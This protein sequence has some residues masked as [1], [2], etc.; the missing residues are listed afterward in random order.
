MMQPSDEPAGQARAVAG[1]AIER[2]PVTE[3]ELSG[4][5]DAHLADVVQ[6]I[7]D[8]SIRIAQIG[9]RRATDR[10]VWRF[11]R[12][13]ATRRLDAQ[14]KL[15]ARL[16]QLGIEAASGPVSA[17]VRADATADFIS[18]HESR[19][20]AFDRVYLDEQLRDLTEATALVGRIAGHVANRELREALEGLRAKLEVDVRL[21]RSV[22]EDY[23][24]NLR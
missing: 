17:L 18:L 23:L 11:A 1:G 22:R 4:L 12:D 8:D 9:E 14:N 24:R 20:R 13:M 15:R 7:T 6:Q 19:G 2:A 3:A 10:R 21:T 16:S 5:D